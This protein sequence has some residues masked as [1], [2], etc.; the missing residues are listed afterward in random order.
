MKAGSSSSSE[1]AL[2]AGERGRETLGLPSL[3]GK[4]IFWR[5]L[6]ASSLPLL[7]FSFNNSQ[8]SL[9]LSPQQ[10]LHL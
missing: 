3:A 8:S 9:P 5:H 6:P 4:V 1:T 10:C 7:V 2:R